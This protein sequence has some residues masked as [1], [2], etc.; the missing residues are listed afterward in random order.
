MDEVGKW[1]WRW[2]GTS[3]AANRGFWA[4]GEALVDAVVSRYPAN[5]STTEEEL[6]V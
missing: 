6:D 5:F 3:F 1:Y 4:L 2:H